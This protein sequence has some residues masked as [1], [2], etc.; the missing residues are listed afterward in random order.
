M[1]IAY[2][3][4]ATPMMP[5]EEALRMIADIGYDGVELCVSPRHNIM[6]EDM[7]SAQRQQLRKMLRELNLGVPSLFMLGSVFTEDEQAHKRRL[8]LTQQVM[9][10][11]RDLDIGEPPVIS[12]G[13]GGRTAM[14][15]T[16]R[17]LLVQLLEDYAKLASDEGFILAAEPHVNAMVDRSERAIWLMEALNDPL[18]RL[19]FDI[20]HLYLAR[21]PISE[22]V[23]KL[24]PYTAHTHVTD[25]RIL[26]DRFELVPLGQGELDCVEYVK[27]MHEAGWTDFITVEVSTMVWSKED[28]NPFAVAASS[29]STLDNAFKEAGVPRS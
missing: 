15:E 8:H 19:H 5:L 20:V 9:Q 13:I 26:E 25:A 23:H 3:T 6:P 16:H 21:E 29:Y 24:V 14:W 17:R 11:A 28:Y 22:A 4:Y 2:G 1:K 18:I 27:A 12:T 7:D 10:L